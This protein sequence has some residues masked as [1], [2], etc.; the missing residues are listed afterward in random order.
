MQNSLLP[1]YRAKIIFVSPESQRNKFENYK[2]CF[3]GVSLENSNFI[4]PKLI[5]SLEWISNRFSF[6][7]VLIGDSIHRITLESLQDLNPEEAKDKAL[8]LGQ[9]FLYREKSI[10]SQFDKACKFKFVFCSQIQ[11]YHDYAQYHE[12][13]KNLYKEDTLFRTSVRAFG[14]KFHKKK[15]SQLSLEELERRIEKSSDYF[16]EEF[17]IFACLQ[18]RGYPVMVYP[19]SFSTLTEIAEGKHPNALQELKDLTVVSLQLKKR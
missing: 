9:E 16:L 7:C 19:G 12:S 14:E 15:Q 5:A 1:R 11:Q 2:S 3:C 10:F 6:C 4:R 18:R 17:A 13:L 8:F